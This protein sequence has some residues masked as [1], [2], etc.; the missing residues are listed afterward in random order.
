MKAQIQSPEQAFNQ[1]AAMFQKLTGRRSPDILFVA[2]CIWF[3]SAR[4]QA[5][6]IRGF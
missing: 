5:A 4:N 6:W 2:S 3:V 1:S